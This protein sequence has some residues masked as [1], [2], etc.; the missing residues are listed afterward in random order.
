MS[1]GLV[2][3]ICSRF[4]VLP[5]GMHAQSSVK[6]KLGSEPSKINLFPPKVF[7]SL[8]ESTDYNSCKNCFDQLKELRRGNQDD[9]G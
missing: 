6:F 9:A 5:R 1:Q 4:Y 8:A 3:L 7:Q 2:E